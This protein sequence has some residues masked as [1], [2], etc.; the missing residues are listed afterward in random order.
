MDL[1]II[2][3]N[4]NTKELLKDCLSSVF[5]NPPA[6]RHEIIVVDNA[7]TDG[8]QAFVQEHFQTVKL[9]AN[10]E[11]F[12]FAKAN[13]IA[14]SQATGKFML[15]LNSDTIVHGDVLSKSYVYMRENIDVG[16]M[17]CRVLN[18]D[19]SLQ[20]STSQFPTL[21]NL[22]LQ[23]AGLDKISGVSFF[24]RYRMLDWDRRD[25]RSVETISGCYMLLRRTCVED[26]GLLDDSFFFFGEET[27]WCKRARLQAWDIH[28]APVGEITHLGGGSSSG[29]NYH[30][31]L[32]LSQA[33]VRLHLKHGGSARAAFVFFLL[34]SF[35]CSRWLFWAAKT[36]LGNRKTNRARKL[37]FAGVSKNFW[38]AW[39]HEKGPTI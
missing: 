8:S 7:S 3:I 22:T 14:I 15:L 30:R 38:F 27:D 17:G 23:T 24:N 37:H 39:P 12:G 2:I 29:L 26:V 35:N 11:N 6:C 31:D 5:V 19:G 10:K 32:M 33:T 18:K 25:A 13:N 21:L 36:A 1:S 16:A 34:L 4:W 28:F 9:I 20:H